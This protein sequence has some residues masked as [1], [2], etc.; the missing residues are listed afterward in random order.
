MPI[1]TL[2]VSERMASCSLLSEIYNV[3]ETSFIHMKMIVKQ[4]DFKSEHKQKGKLRI[5]NKGLFHFNF[6]STNA[7]CITIFEF[8]QNLHVHSPN[9]LDI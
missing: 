7:L 5:R 1:P 2:T 4:N 3:L 6:N 8:D 9:L